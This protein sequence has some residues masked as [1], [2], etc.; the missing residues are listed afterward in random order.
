MEEKETKVFEP[1]PEEQPEET[2]EA[3]EQNLEALESDA[4][5]NILYGM[6]WCIGGLIF[7]FA[8]YYLTEAGGRYVVATGAIIWGAV[9]AFKGLIAYLQVKRALGDSSACKRAIALAAGT[10]VAIAGLTYASWRMVHADEVR[11]VAEE[12]DYDCPELGLRMTIPAGFSELE[13]T[14]E[15]ETETTYAGCRAFAS[16]DTRAISVEGTVGNMSEEV[17]TAEDIEVYLTE[18][19]EKF[20]DGGIDT[21]GFVTIGGVQMMKHVGTRT[22]NPEWKSVMYDAVHKGSLITIYYHATEGDGDPSQEADA[23]VSEC[24]AFY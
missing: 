19:A 23:F 6:L 12:Q 7:S 18:E 16:N 8:S 21:R 13:A 22:Q 15:E 10:T 3:Q 20:F 4:R 5:R 1:L 2:A 24:V 17:A 9:Q 14:S 11:I